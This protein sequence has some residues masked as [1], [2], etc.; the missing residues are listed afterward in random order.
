M[1]LQIF[2]DGEVGLVP[3]VC[4][5]YGCI[6]RRLVCFTLTSFVTSFKIIAKY[7]SDC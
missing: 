6:F 4:L 7:A 3:H 1:S 5:I 2:D